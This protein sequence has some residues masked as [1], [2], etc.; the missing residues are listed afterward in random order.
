MASDL[1][2]SK[3]ITVSIVS[4]GHLALIRPLLE[5]LDA[6][7]HRV[8]EKVVVT[9]NI[10]EPDLL[11]GLHLQSSLELIRNQ[12]PKGFG[13]NHNQAFQACSTPWFL[14]L[15]PD[16]HFD[17]EILQ[18]LIGEAK[19][20]SGLLT[21]RIQEPEKDAPEP[22]RALVTPFEILG[23]KR[24]GY[25]FPSHPAWI[26]GLFMLFR[27]VAYRQIKGFDERFFMY[28][29]DV[30]ICARLQ[31]AGW[32]LQA[33]DALVAVHDAR[34]ASHRSIKHF[35]W[36]ASSLLQIWTSKPFWHFRAKVIGH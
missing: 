21:P 3:P 33:E 32:A 28:G 25:Q 22:H 26:P 35:Y 6:L 20:G 15:N 27:S 16:M 5:Q 13:A 34:R 8:I 31:L 36:H 30:D 24:P 10:H 19:T 1:H 7:S 29:E 11:A 9:L 18:R 12:T 14:V 2:P 17:V 23:R 4:H